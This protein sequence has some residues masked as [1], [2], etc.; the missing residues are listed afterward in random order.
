MAY[1]SSSAQGFPQPYQEIDEDE[2]NNVVISQKRLELDTP[3]KAEEPEVLFVGVNL[4]KTPNNKKKKLECPGAPKVIKKPKITKVNRS[5]Q[6][7]LII[8][9]TGEMSEEQRKGKKNP[10]MTVTVRKVLTDGDTVFR[11]EKAYEKSEIKPIMDWVANVTH[12]LTTLMQNVDTLT[13]TVRAIDG[14]SIE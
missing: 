7:K 12:D 5:E 4:P 11:T 2:L 9:L 10:L 14:A 8:D 1:T 3:T 13:V 6:K